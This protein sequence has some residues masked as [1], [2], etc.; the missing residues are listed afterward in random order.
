MKTLW[1]VPLLLLSACATA[2]NTP[3]QH[4]P[5]T[6]DP[7]GAFVI[8]DCGKAPHDGG[9]T[10]AAVTLDRAAE[11]CAITLSKQGY[12]PKSIAFE[13]QT[14][15]VVAANRGLGVVTGIF[16]GLGLLFLSEDF[17]ALVEL[18]L[19]PSE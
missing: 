6:S 9:V 16:T 17:D 19:R 2:I 4:V 3:Y 1:I 11:H 10:P 15:R 8:V 12:E 18:T 13:R 5:V 14:S 7:P